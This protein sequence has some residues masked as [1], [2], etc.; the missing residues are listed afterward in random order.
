MFALAGNV[1]TT[2]FGSLGSG[3][4][5]RLVPMDTKKAN[6]NPAIANSKRPPALNSTTMRRLPLRLA[7]LPASSGVVPAVIVSSAS[8]GTATGNKPLASDAGNAGR[9]GI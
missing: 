4:A 5:T 2:D 8:A 3:L 6:D 7:P 9:G 1:A